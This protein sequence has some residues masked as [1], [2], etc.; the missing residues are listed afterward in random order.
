METVEFSDILAA[1]HCPL[2][3]AAGYEPQPL[4]PG[5]ELGR[6]LLE[7]W[8]GDTGRFR[9]VVQSRN[10][11]TKWMART[12]FG[13]AGEKAFPPA[14][15]DQSDYWTEGRIGHALI[16]L[17]GEQKR[18]AICDLP[19]LHRVSGAWEVV[20]CYTGDSPM[21][22]R[23]RSDLIT[24]A[25]WDQ[26]LFRKITGKTLYSR[27]LAPAYRHEEALSVPDTSIAALLT[28]R[29]ALRSAPAA[30]PG[31]HCSD[32][33][34]ERPMKRTWRCPIREQDNCSAITAYNS[35]NNPYSD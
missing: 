35:G 26:S 9:K 7:D 14:P 17:P 6:K 1:L 28:Q 16:E 20:Y 3:A 24:R 13:M 2:A 18:L 33:K 21:D 32:V 27:L 12:R 25:Q 4:F 11:A 8:P 5:Y 22:V 34:K 23:R 30:T 31:L 10:S 19:Y 29:E 15:Q